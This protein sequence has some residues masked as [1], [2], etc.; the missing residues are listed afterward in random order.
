MLF[1]QPAFLFVFLPIVLAAFYLALLVERLPRRW[2]GWASEASTWVLV[3]AGAYFV[4]A[5]GQAFLALPGSA[6]AFAPAGALVLFCLVVSSLVDSSRGEATFDRSIDV[7]LYVLQFPLLVAGPIIR[8]KDFASQRARRAVGMGPFTYGVRRVVTGLVKAVL[9]GGTLAAPANA[10]FAQPSWQLTTDAAWLGAACYGLQIYFQFSGYSDVAIGLGRMLGFRYPENFRRPYTA[11]SMRDFWRHWNVTL[12]QWLRDY[13]YLPIAG[14]DNPTPRLYLNM[15]VGFCLMG[16]WHGGRWTVVAW[17]VYSSLWLALE[18]IG[19]GDRIDRLPVALRHLY[20]LFVVGV[21]WVILRP[22]VEAG[23]LRY[24]AIMA[25]AQGRD[26]TA[27]GYMTL[28]RWAALATAV[29]FAGPL[30][31]WISRWRVSV[32]A[33]TTSLLMMMTAMG[34]L[35]W[36]S[37]TDFVDSIRHHDRA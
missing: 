30:V 12:V 26:F 8:F 3:G 5:G 34:V 29:L 18:A 27:L 15:V 13:L 23:T 24:L 32:D 35:A 2:F 9:V 28:W 22:G 10:I 7:T 16:L 20:V 14:R 4:W 6:P 21:G 37:G 36:K 31:P 1:D 17:A 11:A 19:L 33:A 25:G